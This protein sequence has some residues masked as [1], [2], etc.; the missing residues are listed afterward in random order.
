MNQVKRTRARKV[1]PS[2]TRF[3][4][5]AHNIRN[6]MTCAGIYFLCRCSMTIAVYD[7]NAPRNTDNLY[8]IFE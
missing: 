1:I 3:F 5:D 6:S 2:K 8:D 4:G 7:G